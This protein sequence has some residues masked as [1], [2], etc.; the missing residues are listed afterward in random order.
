MDSSPRTDMLAHKRFH[1]SIQSIFLLRVLKKL[2]KWINKKF[3]IKKYYF[4][5]KS[6]HTPTLD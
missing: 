2:S 3:I 4:F 5:G 6:L 1:L